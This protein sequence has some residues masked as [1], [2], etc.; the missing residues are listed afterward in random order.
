MRGNRK[1][2]TRPELRLRSELHRRGLRFRK[3]Y[4]V[5]LGTRSVRAD[6]A[7]TRQKVV[8][9][10]DGCFWHCCPDHGTAPRS[11]AGYWRSKLDRNVARDLIQTEQLQAAG[12]LVMRVWE[13]EPPSQ[14]ADRVLTSLGAHRCTS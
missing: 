2:D 7:F 3:D 12:W 13:H 14:A 1:R 5:S 10:V 9:F 11:N 6:V 8:V 4:P